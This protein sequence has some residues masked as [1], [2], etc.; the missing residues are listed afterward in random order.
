MAEATA[1]TLHPV[2]FTEAP[3]EREFEVIDSEERK[4]LT[5]Q[6]DWKDPR[7]SG[8][9]YGIEFEKSNA[10]VRLTWW[11]DTP[12]EWEAFRVWVL[13]LQE[14]LESCV[15]AS[16]KKDGPKPHGEGISQP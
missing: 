5:V 7:N 15:R 12:V 13:R 1:C 16:E 3:A 10:S 4:Q 11:H 6:R 14:F 2:G 9:R 8:F